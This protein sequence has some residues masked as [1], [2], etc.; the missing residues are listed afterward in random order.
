MEHL[1]KTRLLKNIKEDGDF[2]ETQYGFRE[3]R[4]TIDDI[5]YVIKMAEEAKKKE[6]TFCYDS[7]RC[8]E[9][10]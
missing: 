7:S 4:S 6:E 8:E 1:I 5:K 9:R 10:F 3:G 2:S